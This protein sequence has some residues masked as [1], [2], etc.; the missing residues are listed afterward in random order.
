MS[1]CIGC[2]TVPLLF[3]EIMPVNYFLSVLFGARSKYFNLI[4]PSVLIILVVKLIYNWKSH[5]IYQIPII[6]SYEVPVGMLSSV[7]LEIHKHK[8]KTTP[9]YVY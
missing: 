1:L 3:P 6:Y 7:T 9:S 4:Q 5:Y 2:H 8:Y